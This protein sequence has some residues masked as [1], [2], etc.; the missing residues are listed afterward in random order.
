MGNCLDFLEKSHEPRQMP[1]FSYRGSGKC[2]LAPGESVAR[3]CSDRF[4]IHLVVS[5]EGF[6]FTG[7]AADRISMAS[8]FVTVPGRAARIQASRGGGLSIRWAEFIG[9]PEDAFLR[10]AQ[11]LGRAGVIECE[12]IENVERAMFALSES[13]EGSSADTPAEW[14]RRHGL[15]YQ[16]VGAVLSHDRESGRIGPYGNQIGNAVE[17]ARRHYAQG[18]TVQDLADHACLERKYFSRLF[19]ARTGIGPKEYLLM[20]KIRKSLSLLRDGALSVKEIAAIVGYDDSFSFSK[21]FSQAVG[22]SPTEFRRQLQRESLRRKIP[23]RARLA[24]FLTRQE[25]TIAAGDRDSN[26]ERMRL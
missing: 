15:L 2:D 14:L 6:L 12:D 24:G 18:I 19:K 8:I 23:A 17:F 21:M 25:G 26:L 5:G 22:K 11:S 10:N 3:D 13:S 20:L 9:D 7:A 4:A 1:Q 16:L